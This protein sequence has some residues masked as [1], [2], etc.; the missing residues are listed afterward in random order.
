M[1]GITA[2]VLALEFSPQPDWPFW[3][4]VTQTNSSVS[5]F[6]PSLSELLPPLERRGPDGTL[7]HEIYVS[8]QV[9]IYAASTLLSLRSPAVIPNNEAIICDEKNENENENENSVILAYNGEIYGYDD[10]EF[11]TNV[12]DTSFI[13]DLLNDTVSECN[14]K[15]NDDDDEGKILLGRLDRLQGPWAMIFWSPVTRRLYFGKDVLG[16][17]SLLMRIVENSHIVITSV[18]PPHMKDSFAEIPP[19]GLAY[20]DIS[21]TEK[22][23]LDVVRR[24]SRSVVPTRLIN[25]ATTVTG[26]KNYVAGSAAD[27]YVSFLPR[28]WLRCARWHHDNT[29]GY[30]NGFVS[31]DSEKVRKSEEEETERV[32]AGKKHASEF[33][34]LLRNAVRR[35]LTVSLSGWRGGSGPKFALLF[36]GGIDSMVLGRLL[37]EELPMNESLLLVNIAFG[38]DSDSLFAC[39]DRQ[40]AL[41]G[42]EELKDLSSCTSTNGRKRDIHLICVD[43]GSE[44][45]KDVLTSTVQNLVHPCAQPMDATIGTAIWLAVRGCRSVTENKILMGNVRVVFS[46]L[47]ADELMA[48]YKGRHRTVFRTEGVKGVE[49][50]IDA[51]LSRLWFRNLGR[52]DRLVAD[53]GREVRHPFLD[54][55]VISFVTGL[56]LIPCVCDLALGDGVGDKALLRQAGKLLGLS[57]QATK[58]AKRAIQFGSRS[59]QVIERKK[60]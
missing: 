16:R 39:P 21:N 57:E 19:I 55:N 56:P 29:D 58:R 59:K 32:E 36:S 20:I 34:C 11:D 49:R 60:R 23:L 18:P 48:G 51:D 46:G 4:Q 15:S 54:E 27:M 31:R 35:R 52:D 26:E 53:H 40:T 44:E 43:V 28:K 1:C 37:D 38:D 30:N 24:E 17:R 14:S 6:T 3:G 33:V 7:E 50:E 10:E 41:S 8:D 5:V 42:Y 2:L 13:Q 45:A 12:S 25:R 22:L 47:G 9:K